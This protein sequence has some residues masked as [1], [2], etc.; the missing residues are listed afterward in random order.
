MPGPWSLTAT[1][2]AST[3]DVDRLP[4]VVELGGVVEQVGHGPLDG[5]L[6]GADRRFVGDDG[7]APSRATLES[8]DDPPHDVAEREL[9][10]RLVGRDAAGDRD[11]LVDEVDHLLDLAVE[12]GD[13]LLAVV[14]GKIGV[15]AQ[16]V[17]VRAQARQR[18]AQF[19]PG[20][21]D[22]PSLLG[23]GPVERLEHRPER[24][25]EPADLVVAVARHVDVEA[26]GRA[27]RVG[28]RRQAAQR[29]RHLGGD[30]RARAA[31]RR[32][33]R[34]RRRTTMRMRRERRT[35]S[36]SVSGRATCTAPLA[37][38]VVRAR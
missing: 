22:E 27:H 17:E 29:S 19:V 28:G 7:E 24:R 18:R 12:V 5:G 26:A 11:D 23:T 33:S 25:T 10:R 6:L 34:E 4:G 35:R 31:W 38:P 13:D 30:Q 14:V 37:N 16:H 9:R 32:R 21:L 8:F 15:P 20:V 3:C 1:A 2:P 36:T